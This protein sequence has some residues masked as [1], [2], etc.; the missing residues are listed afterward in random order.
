MK[1]YVF[2]I[3]VF[4]YGWLVSFKDTKTGEFTDFINTHASETTDSW[5]RVWMDNQELVLCGFNNKHYDNYILKA[6]YHQFE[7]ADIKALNDWIIGGNQGWE[8]PKW[9][10][11]KQTF[12]VYDIRDDLPI[13]LSLKEIE[14]N[15][16]LPI[17]ESPVPF[18]LDRPLTS[19]E[20]DEVVK[21]CHWDIDATDKL[22][23]ERQAYLD[24]KAYVGKLAGLTKVQALGMTNAKLTAAYLAGLNAKPIDRH[25]EL[26]YKLPDNLEVE[27]KQ[28][29]SFFE[30]ID[31][32]YERKETVLIAGVEHTLAYGGLHGARPNYIGKTE[33]GERYL[34]NA[35]VVSYYPSLMIKNNY[36]SRAVPNPE[37]YEK[38][39]TDRIEAKRSGDKEKADALKL[40]LNTTYGAMK[41]QYNPLY[42]PLMANSVCISGQLYLIDLIE[43]L[44]RLASFELVQSNT[45]G[46][47]FAIGESDKASVLDVVEKWEKR[48]GFKMEYDDVD[49]IYQKDVN[50]YVLRNKGGKVKVKGGYVSNYEGGGVNNASIP[51]VAKAIVEYLLNDVPVEDTITI[52]QNESIIDYQM[53]AKTGRTYDKTV[54]EIDGALIEVQRV[55]RVYAT[56]DE[57]YGT[58]YKVKESENRKDK[59]ANL[60]DHCVI[61]NDNK[62]KLHDIDLL[63]YINMANKRIEDFIG[64]QPTK[65][66]KK[67]EESEMT[68]TAEKKTTPTKASAPLT[69]AQKLFELRKVLSSFV[70][71]RDGKNLQQKYKYI[72][73][74][75]YKKYF[76]KAL[77]QC[78]LDYYTDVISMEFIPS[79][80]DKMHLTSIK[81]EYTIIDP[82]SGE[83]RTYQGF[84]QGADMHDKGYYK[85]VTGALKYFIN[86]NFLINDNSDPE[87]DEEDVKPTNKRPA[88]PEKREE[89]K[90]EIMSKDEPVT[91]AQKARIKELRD[92]LKE[93]GGHEDVVK[94]VNAT[95]KAG[96]TKVQANALIMELDELVDGLED[97]DE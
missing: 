90:K 13:T 28:V 9:N 53:I 57:R 52:R 56:H 89:I 15:M 62:L 93:A 67:K 71:E 44:Q 68:T 86:S 95:M 59:I 87:N 37:D 75:Q 60:P 10:Y 43:K 77:E 69:L 51:I 55:N 35:D 32:T 29:L 3:E 88:A 72:S 11:H 48:T 54:H 4:R 76:E 19:E 96:P 21:Y 7:I 81:V 1:H 61:D 33:P 18:D 83:G 26:E 50:N 12:E 42:D 16:G 2:D 20:W 63:F 46:I 22:R 74:A 8:W 73:E 70:W 85:A 79:I 58:I 78:E 82:V 49:V 41:N 97:D 5:L 64:D 47:L 17:V 14:G 91:D 80:T 40:V 25:D 6:I 92:V 39:F 24:S 65:D 31:P 34:V 66:K 23:K 27:N 38:V 84:G 45:D 94:K 30:E 36:V